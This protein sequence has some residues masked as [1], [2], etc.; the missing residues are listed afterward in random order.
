MCGIAGI[1]SGNKLAGKIPE[2]LLKMASVLSHRGPDDEGYVLF[3]GSKAQCCG[4]TDTP[5]E[6]W[7]N[8]S[9]YASVEQISDRDK[10]S[11]DIFLGFAHRRLSVIDLSAAGHQPMCNDDASVWVSCNGEIYNYIELRAELTAKGFTF[12]TRSDIEVL[13]KA[14]ELWGI[15][16]LEHLNGMWAF[17][18]YDRKKNI[19]FGSRD[20]FGVK[21]LYY[22]YSEFFAFASEQKALLKLPIRKNL[23]HQAVLDFIVHGRVEEGEKGFYSDISELQPS[24][25]F[26]YDLD[27]GNFSV[28]PYYKLTFHTGYE[29]FDPQKSSEHIETVKEKIFNAVSLRLRS[30]VPVGFCL[31]GGIDSSSIVGVAKK[32]N[33]SNRL[34]QLNQ[35]LFA[36]TATHG[37]KFLSDEEKWAAIVASKHNLNWLK[38]HCSPGEMFDKLEQIIYYQDSPLFS[39]STYAQNKVMQLAKENGITILLD[40]QGGDELFAG[41]VPFYISFYFELL[42]RLKFGRLF[43]E[44]F[45]LKNAPFNGKILGRSMLKAVIN[46][47]PLKALKGNLFNYGHEEIQFINKSYLRENRSDFILAPDYSTKGM[48]QWLAGFFTT[49]FLKNLLRWEDRCSMQYSVESRT[50]FADDLD[51]IESVFSVPSA[52]K[53]FRGSSKYLLREAMKEVLPVE[54]YKRSDKLG[55]S[56]PQS[57]WLISESARMKTLIEELKDYDSDKIFHNEAILK[58]WE[59]IFKAGG[60]F[61]LQDFVWRYLN[62]LIWRKVNQDSFY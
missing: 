60:N 58:Q 57:Y 36:F 18:I 6:S 2:M 9:L 20:R 48:N 10:F 41:Y 37:K 14:Y 4:G 26:Y 32:I 49:Y 23:S 53:I 31:S 38:T 1:Y 11:N 33:D 24:H 52:Y 5:A 59:N 39:T 55:F 22:Y 30:D 46:D 47:L 15:N 61:K 56:T 40:G 13:L 25:F 29:K 34:N 3:S 43:N 19:L 12:K 44:W 45:N 54:I 35:N 50:P 27:S 28:K 62:F 21:P 8:G 42:K 17:V 51:L 7:N 16:C